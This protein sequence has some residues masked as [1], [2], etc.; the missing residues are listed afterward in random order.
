MRS[1]K[2]TLCFE[3]IKCFDGMPFYINYHNARIARTIGLNLNLH[4]FIFSPSDELLRCKVIYDEEGVKSINYFPYK[5]RE[6]KSFKLVTSDNIVYDKKY[7]DRSEIDKLYAKRGECD[8]VIIVKNG[9]V[10]DTSIA[11][12]AFFIED[13]WLTPREPLLLGTTRARLL[14]EKEIFEADIDIKMLKKASKIA[15]MNAMVGFE[16]VNE[17]YIEG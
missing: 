12:L 13:R 5:K 17:F 8:E 14:D 7:L 15:I 16:V 4:D 11:N 9:F 10:T 1:F 2:E 3:T 6:I